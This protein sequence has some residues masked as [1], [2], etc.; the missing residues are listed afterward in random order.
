VA[1]PA[2]KLGL[3]VELALG[4]DLTASPLTWAWTDI[5]RYVRFADGVVITRGRADE[6]STAAPSKA[7]LTLLND[8]RFSPRNPVG[9]YYGQIGRNTPLRVLVRPDTNTSADTF[10]R[11]TSNGWGTADSGGAW[12]VNGTASEYSTTGSTARITMASANV[13]RYATLATSLITFDITVRIRTTA[14]ATGAS[15][16]GGGL[17]RFADTSNF[18]RVDVVF[19]TDQSITATIISRTAGVD[20]T[21]ATATTSLTH[22]ANT[23]YRLR[24]Q[25]HSAGGGYMRAKVWLDGATEPST[26]DVQVGVGANST[27]GLMGLTAI[28]TTG[29]TNASAVVEFDDW[30]LTDGWL[31]RHTGYVDDWPP[32][33]NDAGLKQMLAPITASGLTRRLGQGETTG[34]AIKRG[35][36][37]IGLIPKA[38]WPCEDGSQSVQIASALAGGLPMWITPPESLGTGAAAGSNPLIVV[39][40]TGRIVGKVAPY[41][42]TDWSVQWLMNIPTAPAG[43]QALMR[44][45][46]SGTYPTWQLVLTPGTPDLLQLRA[47]DASN[48]EQLADTGVSLPSVYATQWWLAVS[49]AKSGSDIAWT[50]N[51][52][53]SGANGTGKSGTKVS[54]TAGTV[55]E[56]SFGNGS[57]A[58]LLSGATLGHIVVWDDATVSPAGDAAAGWAGEFLHDRWVRMGNQE[59]ASVSLPTTPSNMITP[60]GPP[61]SSTLLAQ[62]REMEA[63]EHGIMYDDIHGS[64]ALLVREG[65]YDQA[66]SLTL[67]VAQK[68]VAWPLDPADDDQQLANDCVASQPSGSSYHHSD[69]TSS[70]S[71]TAVGVY[72]KPISANVYIPQDLRQAA[73]FQVALG[74]VDEIRYPTVP[75]ELTRNPSLIP[76][77]LA[78]EIGERI[79]VTNAPTAL[80]YNTIDLALEGYT[81]RLDT[82]RWTVAAN[83][84]AYKPWNAW[85]MENGIGNLSRLDSGASTLTS[86][87]TTTATSM[88]VTT[89]AGYPVWTTGVVQ[90]DINVAGERMTVTNISGVSSPQTFTVTR[91]VNGVVK[92]QLAGATFTLWN[93]SGLAR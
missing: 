47:Y 44:W 43:G 22:A 16:K 75:I 57:G 65:R 41:T 3:M 87:L 69:T 81:E 2:T 21:A 86:A 46:T 80:T 93:P 84:S 91:S 83:T 89:T 52:Y 38:Y 32:R 39:S 1:F 33:W 85:I 13:R 9:P 20:T 79:Q 26:W 4:A 58:N 88:S 36:Q 64:V 40:N 31:R 71:T 55:T 19:G 35:V 11:T 12:T 63:T 10:P 30:A 76:S 17:V 23:W 37:T 27:A 14:L 61:T 51:L 6:F 70:L 54:A 7:S 82:E 74:T 67:D 59:H 8:G 62:L 53:T 77:W 49:A 48:V 60:M 56:V 90:F 29:N 45:Q 78:T 92:A 15:L 24:L 72:S 25:S 68:Q 34:S 42:G 5:S 28:R 73:E 18:N 66:V 50:Y